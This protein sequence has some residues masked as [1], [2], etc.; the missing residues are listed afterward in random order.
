MNPACVIAVARE[1]IRSVEHF[2]VLETAVVT[3][4]IS[5]SN[6][7]PWKPPRPHVEMGAAATMRASVL[8]IAAG[9]IIIAPKIPASFIPA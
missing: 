2:A 1:A 4:A 7:N 5:S 9:T 3:I 8:T 6:A